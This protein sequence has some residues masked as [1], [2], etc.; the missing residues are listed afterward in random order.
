[1]DILK[2]CYNSAAHFYGRG[3]DIFWK[4][5]FTW[6]RK[7]IKNTLEK[8]QISVE[9][10]A[11]ILDLGCGTGIASE[12]LLKLY[13]QIGEIFGIDLSPKMGNEATKTLGKKFT[14]Y[15]GDYTNSVLWQ[16]ISKKFQGVLAFYTFHWIP[17]SNYSTVIQHI[18]EV[19]ENRGWIIGIA[20]GPKELGGIFD[21]TIEELLQIYFPPEKVS[22]ILS[23]WNP[24]EVSEIEETFDKNNFSNIQI[25][26]V[27]YS[28]LLQNYRA[29]LSIILYQ[30]NFWLADL[31]PNLFT[32]V[33][34]KLADFIKNDSR[35]SDKN[36]MIKVPHHFIVFEAHKE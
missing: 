16:G 29:L 8:A 26:S 35:F 18:Y 1:M 6:L 2:K 15:N 28:V 36:G 14:F 23:R 20:M 27:R 21:D 22:S 11:S 24:K 25:T 19:L 34:K 12:E 3:S 10:N 33:R 7:T 30:Y 4:N 5:R 13:P 17:L 9:P 32:S 31:S